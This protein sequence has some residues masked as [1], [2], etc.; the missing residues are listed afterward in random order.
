MKLLLLQQHLLENEW[1]LALDSRSNVI[2]E[3]L[4]NELKEQRYVEF[5]A[6]MG[7]ETVKEAY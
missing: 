1:K 2:S 4:Y 6:G 7:G 5:E 3:Q